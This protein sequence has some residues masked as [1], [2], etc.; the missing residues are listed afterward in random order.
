MDAASY[1][2]LSEGT[3]EIPYAAVLYRP[4]GSS[5]GFID[6][7]DV[8]MFTL[9]LNPTRKQRYR[10]NARVSELA[11]EVTT[12]ID[13]TI[14]AKFMQKTDFI[15]AEALMG[16]ILKVQQVAGALTKDYDNLVPGQFY[17]VGGYDAPSGAAQ[18]PAACQA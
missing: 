13:S 12:R 10:K 8:D 5:G 6:G 4:A 17:A 2:P 9:N 1:T 15:R 18:G 14:T 11:T 7:G 16:T 3:Y